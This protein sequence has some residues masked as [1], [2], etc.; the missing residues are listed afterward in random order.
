[1]MGDRM[2]GLRMTMIRY[3]IVIVDGFRG[4]RG[5]DVVSVL[6]LINFEFVRK[7]VFP[8][9]FQLLMR[10]RLDAFLV[11]LLAIINFRRGAGVNLSEFHAVFFGERLSWTSR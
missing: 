4:F 7:F 5:D 3:G 1:M 9:H 6:H 11:V 2:L 8:S 10:R